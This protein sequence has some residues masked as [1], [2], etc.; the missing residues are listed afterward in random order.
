MIARRVALAAL[1]LAAC[2]RGRAGDGSMLDRI[3]A[4][5]DLVVLVRP[6]E[7][8]DTWFGPLAI[9]QARR[10][11][12]PDCVLARARAATAVV[13]ARSHTLPD[14]GW[15]LAITGGGDA[16]CPPLVTRGAV[17]TW[18]RGLEPR[19]GDGDGFFDDRGR[20]ARW[21]LLPARP[22]RGL[23]DHELSAGILAHVDAWID[24]RDG[25]DGAAAV[26]FDAPEAADGAR[27]RLERWRADL[28]R[29]RMGGAWPAVEALAVTGPARGDATL[30]LT[31]RL[32]GAP[33]AAAAPLLAT[34]IVLGADRSD[35]APCPL[36]SEAERW[37]L[38]CEGGEVAVPRAVRDELVTRAAVHFAD[39]RVVSTMSGGELAGVRLSVVGATSPLR[40]LGLREGDWLQT[41]DGVTITSVDQLAARARA[42]EPGAVVILGLLR[43]GRP[44][45]LRL[46]LR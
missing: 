11:E 44:R 38:Q 37:R 35:R 10:A 19:T 36:A 27:A 13:I 5:A 12:V 31:L 17:A 29:D 33:G 26:R 32:P 25:I 22:I 7:V 28:D 42:A 21:G 43:G 20:R 15:L 45:A 14:D 6:A 40:A 34:A 41:V 16:P 30:E 46:K 1:A 18:S 8:A 4:E 24:P 3:P 2:K 9:A 23:A 39:D